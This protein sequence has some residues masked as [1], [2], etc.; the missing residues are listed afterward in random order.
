MRCKY[1]NKAEGYIDPEYLNR[2]FSNDIVF[3]LVIQLS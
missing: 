1:L 2:N 3:L